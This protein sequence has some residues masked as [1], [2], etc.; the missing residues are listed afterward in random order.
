MLLDST[1]NILL[2]IVLPA[3]VGGAVMLQILCLYR[4]HRIELHRRMAEAIR[5]RR[6]YEG[7]SASVQD[8]LEY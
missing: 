4:S 8:L 6:E 7:E 2:L 3:L 5:L 1:T